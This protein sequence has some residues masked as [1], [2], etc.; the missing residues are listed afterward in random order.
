MTT[1]QGSEFESRLFTALVRLIDSKRVRTAAY[2]PATNGLIERWHRTLKT[3]IKCLD[4]QRWIDALPVILLCLRTCYKEDLKASPAEFLYGTTLRIPGEFFTHED[5]PCDPNLFLEDFRIYMRKLKPVPDFRHGKR[6]TFYFKELYTCSHVF[7]RQES[8]RKETLDSPYAGP[9]R[10]IERP[11]DR[12]FKIDVNGQPVNITVEW[13]KPAHLPLAEDG[14][15]QGRK[16]NEQERVMKIHRQIT[17][18]SQLTRNLQAINHSSSS[19]EH[20][21]DQR[22][23]D[24]CNLTCD[25][26]IK[27]QHFFFSFILFYI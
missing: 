7:I 25:Q 8:T 2:H 20:I 6:K 10:I 22:G 14:L 4:N 1:D 21:S 17:M 27:T 9:Y 3:A 19:C 13:L 15:A 12:L 16:K 18:R 24:E 23:E 11:S 5:T 26:T